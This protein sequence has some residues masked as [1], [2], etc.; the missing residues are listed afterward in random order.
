[1]KATVCIILAAGGVWV[2]AASAT[3]GTTDRT[4]PGGATASLEHAVGIELAAGHH[5]SAVTSS[6]K[7]RSKYSDSDTDSDELP[8]VPHRAVMPGQKPSGNVTASPTGYSAKHLNRLW[9]RFTGTKQNTKEDKPH[10]PKNGGDV[11]VRAGRW[12][13]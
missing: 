3:T 5:Y 2:A 6:E 4:A 7:G 8:P 12:A 9:G 13:R 1:M 10:T 11:E